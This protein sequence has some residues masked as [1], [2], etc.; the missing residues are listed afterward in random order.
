MKPYHFSWLLIAFATF[1]HAEDY[2]RLD[3]TLLMKK[4]SQITA[5]RQ[6]E[7][8]SIST[9]SS[10]DP[11]KNSTILAFNGKWTFVPKGAV[12]NI[13]TRFADKITTGTDKPEGKLVPFREFHRVNFGWLTTREM[14]DK[15][16][17]GKFKD[18]AQFQKN[19]TGTGMVV[20]ATRKKH[21]VS[22][23]FKNQ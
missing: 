6:A 20:V 8:Q 7:T 1:A 4:G 12:I 17:R 22:T 23:N 15:Q 11:L 16:L 10:R 18:S 5:A 19:L 2:T 13:P 14:T 3:K 21:P 9:V